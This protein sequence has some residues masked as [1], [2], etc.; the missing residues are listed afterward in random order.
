[1]ARSEQPVTKKVMQVSPEV[2]AYNEAWRVHSELFRGSFDPATVG[3][4]PKYIENRLRLAFENGWNGGMNW[5]ESR[6]LKEIKND[7]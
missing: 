2:A 5:I 6:T 1:M 4:D 7:R 3:T